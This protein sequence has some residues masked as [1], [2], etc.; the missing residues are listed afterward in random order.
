M[1]F[2][3]KNPGVGVVLKFHLKNLWHIWS[4]ESETNMR[5]LAIRILL[6]I[7]VILAAAV[8]G[9]AADCASLS[10]TPLPNTT[11]TIAQSIAAGRFVPPY[12]RPIDKLPAFCRLAGVIRPSGD[13]NIQ[14]EVWLPASGWNGKFLSVGNGGFAGSINYFALADDLKRGYAA[15]ATDTGHEGDAED[16]SWAYKHPERIVDF[17][18]RALHATAENAKA[19]I[20]AFYSNQARHSYFDSCSDGGREGLMEAQRFPSDFDGIL[21]GAPANFWTHL[22]AGAMEMIQSMYGK[23]PAGY[24]PS[25]KLPAI[26]AAAL[27]AC[28]AQDGVKDGII[29]DPAR[30]RFDT[31]VLL[32]KGQDSRACLTSPQLG[33]LNT[34]YE[35]AHDS[36]GKQIF[37]GFMPGAED[38]PQGWAPWILGSGPGKA[39]GPVYAENYF[40]YMVFQDPAWNLLSADLDT[41]A[42]AADEKTAAILNA[43]DADLGSFKARG[44]KLILYHGWND[45]AIS[46]LNTI[47]YYKSVVA[48]MG[49]DNTASFVRLYMVPGMQHCIPGPGPNWFGQTGHPTAKGKPYGVFDALEEWVD[50]GIVPRDIIATKYVDDDPTKGVQMT[51]P[52]CP[53]PQ[54]AKYKG[55]GDT[56]DAANFTCE[57]Q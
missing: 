2:L 39:S 4:K 47:N 19:L 5:T 26:Q 12:G 22:L 25:T 15:A 27:A 54:I 34:L 48:K 7:S 40:R 43:T 8:L 41:A 42:A 46:P 36:R 24:I 16:A 52:L 30:C 1:I 53:Y 31:S 21:A 50:K 51:R 9:R 32:C 14:F 18:Y 17:G 6:T 35:G 37:P 44:G 38:G 28:D 10:S 29:S 13:S 20:Q 33:S 56:N 49:A 3:Q 23:D 45:P 11:I 55:T 57:S